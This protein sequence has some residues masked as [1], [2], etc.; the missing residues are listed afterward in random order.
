M[1]N[2]S[3]EISKNKLEKSWNRSQNNENEL[4]N[5]SIIT[6]NFNSINFNKKITTI[7]LLD[8][9]LLS[10][11]PLNKVQTIL[12]ENFP[13]WVINMIEPTVIYTIADGFVENL[14]DGTIQDAN[15]NG[16]LKTGDVFITLQEWKYWFNRIDQ[17]NFLLKIFYRI[18]IVSAIKSEFGFSSSIVPTYVNMS[19]KIFNQR[20]YETT[21]EKFE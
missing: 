12:L 11:L 16:T 6:L 1:P 8:N 15:T 17:S 4:S 3:F 13:E 7:T 5:N 20:I 21:N 9:K 14:K 18:G 10:A 2:E 19:L